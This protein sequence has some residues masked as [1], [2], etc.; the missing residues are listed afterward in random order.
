MK[1]ILVIEDNEAILNNLAEFLEL[2]SYKVYTA[3]NGKLGVEEAI[4]N[5]PDLI[6]CDIMM[7][8]L[9]GFGVLHVIQHNPDLKNTPFIFLT[10]KTDKEDMRRGMAMGADDFIQKPFDPTDLLN[11]I[12]TRLRKAEDY[13]KCPPGTHEV[14]S[15]LKFLTEE[16]AL[17]EFT[18]GRHL[19]HYKKKQIIFSEGNHP[20]RVYYIKKGRVKLYKTNTDGKELIVKVVAEGDFFGYAAI[21]ENTVYKAD[22]QALEDSEVAA[23][24]RQEFEDLLQ[25]HPEI[26]RRFTRLLAHDLTQKEELLIGLAYSSLRRKVADALLH[27]NAQFAN[28][29]SPQTTIKLSR[30]NL[31]A[32]AGTATESLIRTLTDFKEEKLIEIHD[33][34]ITVL[35]PKKLEL[36]IH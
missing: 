4:A 13:K 30:E 18:E 26:A 34:A 7:P 32:I 6:I 23:I 28:E 22:A 21:L 24:P 27:L 3:K 9:D 25:T 10:A 31:A 12:E 19:N 35:N 8:E 1:K 17:E 5:T 33:G 20:V 16:R 2:S 36:Y 11:S 14:N 15:T 29:S